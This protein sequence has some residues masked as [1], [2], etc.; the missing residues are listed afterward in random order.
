MT[1]PSEPG[2][3]PALRLRPVQPG[4]DDQFLFDLFRAH[5]GHVFAYLPVAQQEPLLRMQFQARQSGYQNSYPES[6]DRLV[7]WEQT[8]I[9]RI[10]TADLAAELRIVDIALRPEHCG[11]GFGTRLLA[12][13]RQ[14][15]MAA[16]LP[17]RLSV[18]RNNIRAWRFYARLGLAVYDEGPFYVGLTTSP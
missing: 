16:G 15:A 3:A 10:W 12:A 7:L 13:E 11:R 4:A 9:G 14:R 2:A 6:V 18:D 17:L 1:A 5:Q 8:P